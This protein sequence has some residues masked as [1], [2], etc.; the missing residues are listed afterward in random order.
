VTAVE[1]LMS[2]RQIV[3][4]CWIFTGATTRNGYGSI[5]AGGR[6]QYAH[7]LAYES[8]VGAIPDGSDL[9]HLCR[10]RACFNPEHLEPVDRHENL[11]RSPLAWQAN[12]QKQH[13]PRGHEYTADNTTGIPYVRKDGSRGESR[14]C[15]ACRRA[16][17]HARKAAA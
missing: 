6:T 15:I 5:S 11:H 12:A 14:A 3:G 4:D 2:K 1:R 17:Y 10:V 16:R 13:C 7:R 8:F 9:D